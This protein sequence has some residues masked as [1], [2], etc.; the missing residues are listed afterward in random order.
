MENTPN[1]IGVRSIVRS[2]V[3]PALG[4]GVVKS[5]SD[6]GQFANVVFEYRDS[7]AQSTKCRIEHLRIVSDKDLKMKA[8]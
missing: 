2:V 4:F 5:M 8:A 1:K 7:A 6:D 3:T